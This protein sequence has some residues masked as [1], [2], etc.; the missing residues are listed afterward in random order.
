MRDQPG[1]SSRFWRN[2]EPHLYEE[3]KDTSGSIPHYRLE[4][5]REQA[6]GFVPPGPRQPE[7]ELPTGT[8]AKGKH[9]DWVPQ[10]KK[11]NEQELDED[12]EDF[13][14]KSFLGPRCPSLSPPKKNYEDEVDTLSQL[15]TEE[16]SNISRLEGDIAV[17]IYGTRSAQG[18]CSLLDDPHV[19]A[20][21]HYPA[22]LSKDVKTRLVLM[23]DVL[24]MMNQTRAHHRRILK[25]F[26]DDSE[27]K[28]EEENDDSWEDKD[29]D[30]AERR[31]ISARLQSKPRKNYNLFH[32][33]GY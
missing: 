15:V 33:F 14:A 22:L 2:R 16:L 27:E 18:T 29:E 11:T 20:V 19:V 4:I 12:D 21:T 1:F 32:K 3:I 25:Q 26:Q 23:N 6:F 9:V 13:A 8:A 28:D 7:K 5:P 10:S 17:K 24:T 31:R 30:E